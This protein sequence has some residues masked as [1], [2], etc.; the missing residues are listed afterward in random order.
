MSKRNR[1]SDRDFRS[2]DDDWDFGPGEDDGHGRKRGKDAHK[3]ARRAAE[4]RKDG[5][6]D[7]D[8]WD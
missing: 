4:R 5:R 6:R 3:E 8:F 2:F 7:R 1:G